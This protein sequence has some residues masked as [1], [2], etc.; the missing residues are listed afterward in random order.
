MP[1]DYTIDTTNRIAYFSH[2]GTI[3]IDEIYNHYKRFYFD[4]NSIY[5][6]CIIADLSDTN[7]ARIS[8]IELARLAINIDCYI[9]KLRHVTI[10]YIAPQDLQYGTVR[11]W[12]ATIG[13]GLFKNAGVFRS[14][15]EAHKWLAGVNAAAERREKVNITTQDMNHAEA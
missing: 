8:G 5:C 2:S 14:T 9:E 10:T 4:P 1:C 3:T 15:A 12:L 13:E 11:V 6:N 7:L